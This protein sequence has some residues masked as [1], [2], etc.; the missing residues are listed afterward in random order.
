MSEKTAPQGAS[1]RIRN[2]KVEALAGGPLSLTGIGP[3]TTRRA[4]NLEFNSSSQLWEVLVDG[5]CVHA[6]PDYDAALQWE[7]TFFNKKL[8]T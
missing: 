8:S 6:S 5:K 2:G 1:Y 4:S 3:R 7:R